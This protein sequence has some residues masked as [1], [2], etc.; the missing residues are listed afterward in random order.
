MHWR[1]NDE[2]RDNS[3][4]CLWRAAVVTRHAARLIH[5]VLDKSCLEWSVICL[6]SS[7]QSCDFLSSHVGFATVELEHAEI[8]RH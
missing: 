2:G 1:R 6:L 3:S 8:G 7:F 4:A 5:E